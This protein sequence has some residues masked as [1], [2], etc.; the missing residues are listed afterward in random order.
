MASGPMRLRH[1]G[2][3]ADVA[4][5]HGGRPPLAALADGAVLLRDVGGDVGREVALEVGADGG[6]APDLLGVAGVLD[7]DGGE[8]AERHQELQVLVA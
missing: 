3:A 5:E 4:E 7:P 8:A 1:R 6:L 2:E